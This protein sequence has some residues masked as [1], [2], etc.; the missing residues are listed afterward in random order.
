[1]KPSP[2]IKNLL[3]L[4]GCVAL[5]ASASGQGIIHFRNDPTTLISANGVPMPVP[6]DQQFIF[7]IVLAPATTTTT[8]GV[9]PSYSDPVW[10]NIGGYNTNGAV[11]GRI[12]NRLE[13]DV[14]TPTGYSGGSTVDFIVRGWSA[15][16]GATWAESLAN[17]NNGSP[18]LPMTIGS[19]TVANNVRLG[20][21]LFVPTVFG[22][23]ADQVPGFN[24]T[25]VPEPSS[26]TLAGL[27]LAMLWLFR[28][29]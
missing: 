11:P 15:N 21:D 8:S 18:F 3:A 26:L 24:M 17:W 9:V 23:R 14:V 5:L 10:Q 29:R 25:F 2:T 1:M 13:L 22:W 6:G 7:A 16:A 28:R 27:G 4:L 20:D 19:S 12:I